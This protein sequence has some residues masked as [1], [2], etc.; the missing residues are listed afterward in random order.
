MQCLVPLLMEPPKN[1][2]DGMLTPFAQAMPE[3]Y[4]CESAVN[5]YRNYY[6]GEKSRFAKWRTGVIPVWYSVAVPA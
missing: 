3:K 4:R 2:K 1:I 6:I 5:A